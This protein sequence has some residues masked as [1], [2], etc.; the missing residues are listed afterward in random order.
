MKGIID[1]T[2]REGEQAANVYF[3]LTEK[4]RIIDL[5]IKVGVDEIELGIAVQNPETRE[6]IKQAG[7]LAGCPKLALWCRCLPGDIEQSVRLCPDVLAMSI[8]VSD[9]HIKNKLGR[10]RKWVLARVCE[11]I[12]QV[13]NSS[14]CY[15]SLGLE[16][17]SRAM[18]DF[19]DEVCLL[20]EKEGIN[21]VRFADTV[22]IMDPP[23]IFDAVS[24]LRSLLSI[25]IG[26]HAHND[27]GMATANAVSA[28]AAGADF[29]DVTVNGLGERAGNA[30]L[31]EVVGFLAKRKGTDKYNLKRLRPLSE[32]V[33]KVSGIPLSSRKPVVGKDIFTCESGIHI[34]GLIKNPSNY[35]P[36]DPAEV[37]MRRKFLIGK[38]TGKS[39]LRYKLNSLRTNTEDR[40]LEELLMKVKNESSRLKTSFSDKELLRFCSI[41]SEAVSP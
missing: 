20:A 6:L 7:K 27:F 18:P 28:L 38:K 16:D 2:L 37:S 10:N 29:A 1:S 39:A 13:R 11:G 23:A 36:F 26:M 3:D 22:G 8:P 15:L 21:R 5:L 19:V 30:V 35:E 33:A 41:R 24:R 17:A 4:L 14:S 12:R 32:Y 40:V 34:D 25:D 31:E 9:I